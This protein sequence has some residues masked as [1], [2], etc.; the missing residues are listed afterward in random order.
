MASDG[1]QILDK[2][3]PED[4]ILHKP[5][6]AAGIFI[7]KCLPALPRVEND[8]FTSDDWPYPYII[9]AQYWCN[10]LSDFYSGDAHWKRRGNSCCNI[11]SGGVPG[12]RKDNLIIK[13]IY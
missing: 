1:A 10:N 12:R 8:H 4:K 2:E 3:Y 11:A 6:P 13:N 9:P 5:L 7:Y